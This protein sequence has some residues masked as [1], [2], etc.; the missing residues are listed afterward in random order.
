MNY[1]AEQSS[2]WC[3]W[4]NLPISGSAFLLILLFLDVHD[5]KTK[6]GDG[7]KAVDWFGSLSILG[8]MLM[9]LLGL[10]FGG[11]IFP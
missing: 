7:V 10:E 3:F 4:I 11:A 8:L 2:R 6:L 9:L 5:P 1:R